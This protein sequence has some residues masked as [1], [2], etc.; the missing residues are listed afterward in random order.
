M[1]SSK[2]SLALALCLAL[3]T[4]V[5]IV[6]AASDTTTSAA[7]SA[8]TTTQNNNSSAATTTKV[9]LKAAIKDAAKNL[10]T[11]LKS[12]ITSKTTLPIGVYNDT[13]KHW[14]KDA[15]QAMSNAGYVTGY[16]DG[17]FKP[18]KSM[19]REQIATVYAK[20]INKTA[21]I[22]DDQSAL[23]NQFKDVDTSRWS[24][25]AI[26]TVS[27]AGIMSGYSDGT[28]MPEKEMTRQE[29]A[30]T[31]AN[32]AKKQALKSSSTKDDVSFKDQSKLTSWAKDAVLSLAKDGYIASGSDV[33]FNPSE[34]IT[35]AEVTSILYRMI[36][37]EPVKAVKS[38]KKII[39]PTDIKNPAVSMTSAQQTEVENAAFDELNKFYKQASN[40]QDH[41]VIYWKDNVLHVAMK[42]AANRATVKANLEGNS[43]I[44]VEPSN[45][46]QT[47]YDK[48]DANFRKYYTS[49]EKAGN[50]LASF[51]DVPNNQLYA[52][53]TTASADTQAG[54]LKTF[55][56]KVKMS[57]KN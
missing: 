10:N 24:N 19:S 23:T 31:A 9:D 51:P 43:H 8:T 46:S 27:N 21:G 4:S 13:D 16:S 48:I 50:I 35:R 52:V 42:D 40:F 54:V 29:F 41:G 37:N 28:F 2:L 47:E 32:F 15:I 5:N 20:I 33:M 44:I 39:P 36:N 11:D 55:G 3:G 17:T 7:A 6:N 30:V 25:S 53:V 45:Y 26:A 56:N 22:A 57:V 34:P 18:N 38:A 49:H 1:K 14:A 12:T